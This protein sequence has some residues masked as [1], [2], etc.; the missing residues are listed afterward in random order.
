MKKF[1]LAPTCLLM[2]FAI[3]LFASPGRAGFGTTVPVSAETA[4]SIARS[5]FPVSLSVGTGKLFLTNPVII[6]LDD[7][8]IGLQARLQA[9][10]HRPEEGIAISEEGQV[11]VSGEVGYD[12]KTRE[13]L[14]YAPRIDK[15][16]FDNESEVTKRQRAEVQGAWESQVTSPIRAQVPPHPF[17]LPFKD[18]I[19]DVTYEKRSIFI[20]VW[21]P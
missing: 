13:V 12:L 4:T 3:A 18:G 8:R 20:Q 19:Q 11:L 1:C 17:I 7:R 16:T 6:F 15:L 9:Y 14:L 5:L 21:Y 10:D 2:G